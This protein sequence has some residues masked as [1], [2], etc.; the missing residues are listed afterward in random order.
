MFW[1][2]QKTAM[3]QYT[4]VYFFLFWRQNIIE[5]NINVF[6]TTKQF[7][8]EN[9]QSMKSFLSLI[10]AS[11]FYHAFLWSTKGW[12]RRC[13]GSQ[14]AGMLPQILVSWCHRLEGRILS[15]FSI[16]KF[17]GAK[18]VLRNCKKKKN[19]INIQIKIQETI[20]LKRKLSNKMRYSCCVPL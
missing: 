13:H 11:L 7:S 5:P 16:T 20:H 1:K 15:T 8:Y 4:K 18:R 19:Q 12:H 10:T 3:L 9:R 6:C 17:K 2:S 14:S